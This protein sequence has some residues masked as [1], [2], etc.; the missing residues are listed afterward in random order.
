MPWE[1]SSSA[2]STAEACTCAGISVG[3]RRRTARTSSCW[4]RRSA[5]TSSLRGLAATAERTL[6]FKKRTGRKKVRHTE[7]RRSFRLSHGPDRRQRGYA[8]RP[9]RIRR[10][11]RQRAYRGAH[12][13][14][15]R[16][17]GAPLDRGRL[18][19]IEVAGMLVPTPAASGPVDAAGRA[20]A[21]VTHDEILER[22]L[23]AIDAERAH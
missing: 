3:T 5:I 7:G 6:S 21:H 13:R 12:R 17:P 1:P 15:A 18:P 10:G 4:P 19:G 9:D 22:V 2:G 23:G 11:G 14:D 16:E 8:P 20:E